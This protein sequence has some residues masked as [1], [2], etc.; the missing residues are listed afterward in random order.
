MAY[1]IRLDAYD[2]AA[3][4]YVLFDSANPPGS[5]APVVLDGASWGAPLYGLQESGVRGTL[6]KAT[7]AQQAEN[8]TVTLPVR[9]YGTSKDNLAANL[10]A[11]SNIV[12]LMRTYGGQIVYQSQGQTYRQYFDV[13][14]V[15]GFQVA[16]WG[17]RMEMRYVVDAQAVFSCAPFIRADGLDILDTFATDT[18]ANY[19][20][21]TGSAPITD[22]NVAGGLLD[23]NLQ[24][25]VEHRFVH[26]AYGYT[27]PDMQV[28]VGGA[29]GATITSFKLG[30]VVMRKDAS[31]YLEAYVDDN[32]T[33]SRLRLDKVVAGARTNL[34]TTNLASRVSNG[35]ALVVRGRVERNTVFAEHF[36]APDGKAALAPTT[37]LAAYVMTSAEAAVF[38]LGQSGAG[39]ASF[40]P[41]DTN[42]YIDYVEIL[43]Y[44]YRAATLPDVFNLT[45][46]PGD[47]S[48]AALATVS[49]GVTNTPVMD[50]ALIGW[51]AGA[52]PCNLLDMGT[53]FDAQAVGAWAVAAVTNLNAAATSATRITSASKYGTWSVQVT[54]ISGNAN[55]GASRRVFRKFRRGVP[56][57]FT[58]WVQSGTSTANVHAVVGNS[59][60]NDVATSSNVALSSAWQQLTVTWTPTADRADCYIAVVRNTSGAADVFAIDAEQLYQGSTAPTL[61]SQVSGRGGPPPFGILE[62]EAGVTGTA[63]TSDASSS[64]GFMQQGSALLVCDPNLLTPDTGLAKTA[65]IELW[66]RVKSPADNGSL[67]VVCGWYPMLDAKPDI[68]YSIDHGVAGKSIPIGAG[69]A[70]YKFARFGTLAVPV[71]GD[72]GRIALSATLSAIG[73]GITAS[74]SKRPTANE[75]SA[76]YA[77]GWTNPANAQD[78]NDATFANPAGASGGWN[79]KTFTFGV[80]AGATVVGVKAT[81][82]AGSAA[83]DIGDQIFVALSGDGGSTWTANKYINLP[84]ASAITTSYTLG[85]SSDT[86]GLGSSDSL[87]SDTNFR[88]R[89]VDNGPNPT[90]TEVDQINIVVYYTGAPTNAYID[91]LLAVPARARALT[92]TGVDPPSANHWLPAAGASQDLVKQIAPDLSAQQGWGAASQDVGGLFDAPGLGGS[93]LEL[94]VPAADVVVKL[95]D[96][97]P[98]APSNASA[99]ETLTETA[100]VHFAITPRWSYLRDH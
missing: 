91:Y 23:A 60:A 84:A 22:F 72:R 42:A 29:P 76:G 33:N 26:T 15:P 30:A 1:Y 47:G 69:S 66:G 87:Y 35:A 45:G 12:G 50:F 8:R 100:T 40:T 68:V 9:V 32:G 94:P 67:N 64:A 44:T 43:P 74:A 80:P 83:T 58:I 63:A 53:N 51:M 78:T 99:A 65:L 82:K 56:Y 5:L 59:A 27:V 95:A 13:L 70:T 14:G 2:P 21:D 71:R 55:S 38:G 4:T 3:S 52:A 49:L 88:I 98:D 75:A 41:Q 11:L 46:I 37:S 81:I 85:S 39:G 16:T 93:L 97:I 62:G 31:N 36:A 96:L 10:G 7:A 24:L 18:R 73:T 86:W 61:P 48:A 90:L 34:A 92:A 79:W 57:T 20:S 6:G 89:L 77:N 17:K 54:A 19:T 28:S 25:T